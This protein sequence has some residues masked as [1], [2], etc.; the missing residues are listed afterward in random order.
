MLKRKVMLMKKRLKLFLPVLIFS[1]IVGYCVTS[2]PPKSYA[3]DNIPPNRLVID[4]LTVNNEP[5][6]G[7]AYDIVDEKTGEVIAHADLTEKSS[8]AGYFQ[9]GNYRVVETKRPEGYEKVE[10]VKVTLPY[11]INEDT[12]TRHVIFGAK[13]KLT[14]DRPKMEK[15]PVPI[16]PNP[17]TGDG[18]K[19]LL[20]AGLMSIS[21]GGL[22]LAALKRRDEK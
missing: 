11:K 18:N 19:I 6:L 13:H 14:I 7:F 16:V 5:F 1:I 4:S 8:W 22:T 2:D 12:Y 17:L 9:D 3:T 10:D 15:P 20:F 21:I